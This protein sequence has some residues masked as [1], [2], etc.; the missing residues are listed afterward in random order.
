MFHGKQHPDTLGK[1]E[2]ES[3]LSYLAREQ[4]VAASTQNQAQSAILFLYKEVLQIELPWL[5]EVERAKKP[6]RL[7][8]VL[9]EPETIALL[10]RLAGRIH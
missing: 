3:F 5:D 8:T 4:N 10:G 2:I 6:Q 9:S 7:P 1:R